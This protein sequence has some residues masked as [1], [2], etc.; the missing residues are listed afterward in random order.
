MEQLSNDYRKP[1]HLE[2]TFSFSRALSK[3]LVIA[4][5]SDWFIALFAP[6]MIGPSYYFG[7]GFRRSSENLPVMSMHGDKN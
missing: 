5:S 4:W 1:T 2:R 6:V 3:L 7:I